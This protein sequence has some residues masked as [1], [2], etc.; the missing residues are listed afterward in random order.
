M[1]RKHL[2]P[3]MPPRPLWLVILCLISS[4]AWAAPPPYKLGA[5]D[6]LRIN[7]FGY[8]EMTADVRLDESGNMTYAFVGQLA[9]G[10]HS[11]PEV[12]AMLGKRLV[13]G[14]FIRNPQMSVLVVEYRS[15]TVSVLGQVTKP[16][17]YPLTK[18]STIIDLLANAG[19]V[20]NLVAADEAT[21]L[22]ADGTKVPIDLFALF[23][24]DQTQNSAV[25]GGDTVYVPRASQFYIYG[26][27]QRPGSYRLERDMTVIQA[28]S[29]GGGLT[30]RGT[31]RR[32]TVKRRGADGKE[33]KLGVRG[34]DL[35]HPDDVLLV[36]QSLF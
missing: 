35:L 16:G 1:R 18:P 28:I 14:G 12:E 11:A 5:G 22:R 13:D 29:A 2:F 33:R 20:I 30:P 31:E 23:Q 19:G 24:G 32:A 27:V 3:A 8:P 17:P 25:H 9:A 21:L 4:H 7:V 36:K 26:E 34:S 6:L 10:G 15:Q